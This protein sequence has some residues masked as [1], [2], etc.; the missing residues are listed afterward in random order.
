M[1]D[2]KERTIATTDDHDD[3]ISALQDIGIHSLSERHSHACTTHSLA[4]S[5]F[6][7]HS[8]SENADSEVVEEEDE[9]DLSFPRSL[10][11]IQK[12]KE[13]GPPP[14]L[15]HVI[16]LTAGFVRTSPAAR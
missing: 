9:E 1:Q 8:R 2:R 11:P 6:S 4:H 10:Y 13:E 16:S 12:V 5:A 7:L 3:V 14:H 15:I